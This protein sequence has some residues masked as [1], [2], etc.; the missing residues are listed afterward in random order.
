[1][2]AEVVVHAH[3]VGVV[4]ADGV[5]HAVTNIA[6]VTKRLCHV[7]RQ[8]RLEEVGPSIVTSP[9]H[10]VFESVLR[11]EPV[12][13]NIISRHQETR[14]ARVHLLL[15]DATDAVVC[16]PKPDIVANH[17]ARGD[18]D[19]DLQLRLRLHGVVGAAHAHEDIVH[20]ARVQGAASVRAI[21]PLQQRVGRAQPR[22][23]QD[24]RHTHAVHIPHLDGRGSLR[25][26]KGGEAYAQQHL[27]VLLQ[28]QR[29]F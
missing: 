4:S 8:L 1:M 9:L 21:A 5:V 10:Q 12:H 20:E 14:V 3:A 22:F 7:I 23:Q 29:R 18:A 24:P 2:V 17:V 16:S 13:D 26:D 15:D 19:H 25:P 11:K 27:V 6:C 28:H